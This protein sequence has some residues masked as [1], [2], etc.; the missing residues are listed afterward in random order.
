MSLKL[1]GQF[2]R[3]LSDNVVDVAVVRAGQGR[4]VRAGDAHGRDVHMRFRMKM[5]SYAHLQ[6]WRSCR[7]LK[8][9]SLAGQVR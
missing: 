8:G 6:L 4:P 1:F 9:S 5:R 3:V 7:K 2:L